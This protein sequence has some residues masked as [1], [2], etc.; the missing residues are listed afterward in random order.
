VGFVPQRTTLL[1]TRSS[2]AYSS[3]AT[4]PPSRS[5]SSTSS[6][7]SSNS[8]TKFSGPGSVHGALASS[9]DTRG[10]ISG[11]QGE[12]PPFSPA[13]VLSHSTG[14][15]QIVGQQQATSARNSLLIPPPFPHS[16]S[17]SSSSSATDPAQQQQQQQQQQSQ[18]GCNDGLPH[19]DSGRAAQAPLSESGEGGGTH[20]GGVEASGEQHGG[21]PGASSRSG[22]TPSDLQGANGGAGAG[23][24]GGIKSSGTGAH[25]REV[26]SSE[27]VRRTLLLMDVDK[28]G[29]WEEGA[30]QG[31]TPQQQK[32]QRQQGWEGKGKQSLQR[33]HNSSRQQS[34]EKPSR[35]R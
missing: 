19:T 25:G 7:A 24:S 22:G 33:R 9:S 6:S 17:S 8:S 34:M 32:Q 26:A 2:P 16:G 35:F 15:L 14:T 13:A 27:E 29:D 4:A 1:P 11:A 23:D 3:I 5:S 18:G 21:S 12:G 31:L 28:D 20:A 10:G 30:A